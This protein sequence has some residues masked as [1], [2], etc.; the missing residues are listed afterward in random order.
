MKQITEHQIMAAD[1]SLTLYSI[2]TLSPKFNC[3]LLTTFGG[4]QVVS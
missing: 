2:Q 3:M 4:L 1:I